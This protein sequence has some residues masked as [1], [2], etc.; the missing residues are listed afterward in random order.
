ME[1]K[2]W[3]EVRSEATQRPNSDKASKGTNHPSTSTIP[4]AP[5]RPRRSL[6]LT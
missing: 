5:S 4:A 1:R 6:T 3:M 2:E